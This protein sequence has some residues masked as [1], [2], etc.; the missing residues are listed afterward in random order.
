MQIPRQM[1][2]DQVDW[3]PARSCGPDVVH[4]GGMRKH[5]LSTERLAQGEV[6]LPQGFGLPIRFE[7]R[8]LRRI[9]GN[10]SRDPVRVD[11][12][13]VAKR[14]CPVESRLASTVA[15]HR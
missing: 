10:S 4:L 9:G 8:E 14:R 11:E 3:E 1:D 2:V 7:F 15:T 6:A 5:G 13:K 12:R